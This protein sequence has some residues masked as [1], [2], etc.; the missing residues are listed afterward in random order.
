MSLKK[1][2]LTSFF[3]IVCIFIIVY[4]SLALYVANSASKDTKKHADAILV[5]GAGSYINGSYNPCLVARVTHAVDLYK[6]NYAS[7]IVMSGGYDVEEK[8]T[9]SLTMKKIAIEQG[10]S[11][12]DILLESSSTST[13]ENFAYTAKV[14][15]AAHLKS[16]IIVTE[17]YHEARAGLIATKQKYVFTQS[18]ATNSPCWLP[19]KYVSKYFL[20]EPIAIML[21][22]LQNKL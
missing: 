8:A 7:K 3:I 6:A 10:V 20:K 18:P 19:N 21:Y 9:E 16:I 11:P 4:T 2:L 15:S 13:Y 22:K 14:L 5:L 17:P 12:K 1:Y